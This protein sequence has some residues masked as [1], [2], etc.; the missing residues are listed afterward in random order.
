MYA[1]FRLVVRHRTLSFGWFESGPR[2]RLSVMAD[3]EIYPRYDGT[4]RLVLSVTNR[5]DTP[6]TLTHMVFYQYRS[7]FH[8]WINK[9]LSQGFVARPAVTA[10]MSNL[11][12]ELGVNKIWH[13]ALNYDS[14][15]SE[16]RKKRRLYIGVFASHSN[17][18]F[19]SR[20]PPVKGGPQETGPS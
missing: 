18:V 13:G 6:T 10:G 5:G 16:A 3:A 9:R 15:L 1:D 4:P 11:P 17:R 12:F 19:V 20:V 7:V 14:D 2:L 8:R